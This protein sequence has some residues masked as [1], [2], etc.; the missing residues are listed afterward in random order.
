[1]ISQEVLKK[2]KQIEIYTK[3]L[4]SGSMI[5]DSRSAIKGSG[6][7]FDQIREYTMGDDVRFIDWRSSARMDKLLVKQYFEERNRTVLL[8]VDVSASSSFSSDAQL[9]SD[10]MAQV[11]SVL[12]LVA[13]SGKDN[14][15]LVL[16]SDAIELYI[17][18]AQGRSHVRKIMEKLFDYKAQ[19]KQ[20]NIAV[21]LDF[22]ASLKRKDTILCLISDFIDQ[23]DIEKA[24]RVSARIYDVVAIRCL[25]KLEQQFPDVGFITIQDPETGQVAVAD[26]RAKARGSINELL[27]KRRDDQMG[28]FAKY[29]VD[30]LD[31][32]N[33][34]Q[35]VG[36]LIRFFGRRMR[37]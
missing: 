34:K 16:F 27:R 25:D 4:L 1:M 18:P 24:L 33:N 29:G 3:R 2:I 5:G 17:P 31:I 21:A 12:A 6:M 15:G 37:Y 28:L 19:R 30:C 20:T 13:E 23:H 7:E 36:D 35:F 11:A 26:T 22:A 8:A 32:M 14:V 9:R 10:V